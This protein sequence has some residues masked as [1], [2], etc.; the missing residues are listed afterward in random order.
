MPDTP[1]RSPSP[2][3]D[4]GDDEVSEAAEVG[5]STT[6]EAGPSGEVQAGSSRKGKGKGGQ[7]NRSRVTVV[8]AE[9]KRLKLKCDR[10]QPCTACKS[11]DKSDKCIYSA[12]AHNKVDMHSVN[13]R[14]TN[15]EVAL[16]LIARGIPFEYE[17]SYPP[18]VEEIE[19]RTAEFVAA[20]GTV[21]PNPKLIFT[22]VA[23]NVNQSVNDDPEVVPS[24]PSSLFTCLGDATHE[25]R[26]LICQ[27]EGIQEESCCERNIKFQGA[28]NVIVKE[29]EERDGM[30]VNMTKSVAPQRKPR[31]VP[32]RKS[33]PALALH[34][35]DAMRHL[36]SP[37][38]YYP[39]APPSSAREP[40]PSFYAD[41]TD[42]KKAYV[43]S[44]GSSTPPETPTSA[45]QTL[46]PLGKRSSMPNAVPT[47][48]PAV[49]QDLLKSLPPM[50]KCFELLARAQAILTENPVELGHRSRM[51]AYP[52]ELKDVLTG[53]ELNKAS[54]WVA[55]SKRVKRLWINDRQLRASTRQKPVP[56][57]PS[58][59]PIRSKVPTQDP[60][61]AQAQAL[62]TRG[63]DS[64]KYDAQTPAPVKP[65]D[66]RIVLER[67]KEKEKERS[68]STTKAAA[69]PINE[70]LPFFA[71]ACATFACGADPA[72]DS[73]P[74]D[75]ESAPYLLALAQQALTFWVEGGEHLP[76]SKGMLITDEVV[77]EARA[78]YF[79]TNSIAIQY[80]LTKGST[81][82]Q[83]DRDG[84]KFMSFRHPHRRQLVNLMSKTATQLAA[85]GYEDGLVLVEDKEETIPVDVPMGVQLMGKIG[86][87]EGEEARR[88]LYWQLLFYDTC[89][90]SMFDRE[91]LI[92]RSKYASATLPALAPNY[93]EMVV[94][95]LMSTDA[96]IESSDAAPQPGPAGD[97]PAVRERREIE[98]ERLRVERLF[99]GLRA[100]LT[101]IASTVE[102]RRA[103]GY[104]PEAAEQLSND[105][106]TLLSNTPVELR[107][108]WKQAVEGTSFALLA[109]G[110]SVHTSDKSLGPS[111]RAASGK[112]KGKNRADDGPSN[113][114]SARLTMSKEDEEIQDVGSTDEHAT[115]KL[116]TR[117]LSCELAL[118]AQLLIVRIHY[119]FAKPDAAESSTSPPTP[120]AL[121]DASKAIIRIAKLINPPGQSSSTSLRSRSSTLLS[122]YPL[123]QL[124][125][126]ATVF[127]SQHCFGGAIIKSKDDK[128]GVLKKV[129]GSEELIQT[130]DFGL[131]LLESAYGLSNGAGHATTSSNTTAYPPVPLS[132]KSKMVASLRRQWQMRSSSFTS[133]P[134][135]KRTRSA[136]EGKSAVSAAEP[137]KD[138][139]SPSLEGP[140]A[141]E[142]ARKEDPPPLSA[143]DQPNPQPTPS[144]LSPASAPPTTPSAANP[145]SA[146]VVPRFAAVQDAV[147]KKKGRAASGNRQLTIRARTTKDGSAAPTPRR[148]HDAKSQ[149]P[150]QPLLT[151]A[152]RVL[153]EDG[154]LGYENED[155]APHAAQRAPPAL[156]TVIAPQPIHPPPAA[157]P[158]P[159]PP[160]QQPYN[161]YDA[162]ASTQ[163]QPYP[164]ASNESSPAGQYSNGYDG[165][166]MTQNPMPN[167][168][169]QDY[170]YANYAPQ[171][172]SQNVAFSQQHQPTYAPHPQAPPVAPMAMAPEDY[173]GANSQPFDTSPYMNTPVYGSSSGAD[174]YM[175]QQVP[176]SSYST[177]SYSN[178]LPTTSGGVPGSNWQPPPPAPMQ[179]QMQM[180]THMQQPPQHSFPAWEDHNPGG[181]WAST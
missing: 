157:D 168:P 45:A 74:N 171:V 167:T 155:Q 134:M 5:G 112:S 115:S 106:Q 129:S 149:T 108:A 158:P 37:E 4:T 59:S 107:W 72:K 44:P 163:Q 52:Q 2:M 95:A 51:A 67:E 144:T 172:P 46:P 93:R 63:R 20:G 139:S 111:T 70:S 151:T 29:E 12:E 124:V 33:I 94:E 64:D 147:E 118:L 154:R 39:P 120:V 71:M 170:P 159:P 79:R 152:A 3:S 138:T 82:P 25:Y 32:R 1:E 76:S 57:G 27:A 61:H 174:V 90:A 75:C 31:S 98:E 15:N 77:K 132:V 142:P 30:D 180:Q 143:K 54:G 178:D 13:I 22:Y 116:R 81:S 110:E 148:K 162:T 47:S 78:D 73:E 137:A 14:V 166:T 56:S 26:H 34:T 181:T 42:L 145:T 55:F 165:A 7:Q 164:L 38:K 80:Y 19:R 133:T 173:Y 97:T 8:C 28:A 60:K 146:T 121:L 92:P 141:G 41:S 117:S 6:T 17:C 135:R 21:R 156:Q 18:A 65:I 153:K 169:F 35:P 23:P 62:Y 96:A 100:R 43:G 109:N 69:P 9:C 89:I 130:M 88:R 49:T 99:F 40:A 58:P 103:K 11:K 16:G 127:C 83:A 101:Q 128:T 126:D 122:M 179:M 140:E 136:M 176:T 123:D 150:T 177:L 161:G 53:G 175:K 66:P 119:P 131:H 48:K 84:G 36:P 68:T 114:K 87:A 125:F 86:V 85:W 104:P 102:W 105:V 10:K 91:R 160:Q 24:D 50:P 113:A